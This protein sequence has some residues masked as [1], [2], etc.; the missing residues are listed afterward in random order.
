MFQSK[1]KNDEKNVKKEKTCKRERF[2]RER[3]DATCANNEKKNV[4][5]N[6]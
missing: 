1:K 3:S 5:S 6:V 4:E 2:L